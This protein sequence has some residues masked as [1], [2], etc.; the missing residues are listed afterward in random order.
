MQMGIIAARIQECALQG[1]RVQRARN[2]AASAVKDHVWQY[3]RVQHYMDV[4]FDVTHLGY[5]AM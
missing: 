1:L 4:L 2:V 5:T 3:G